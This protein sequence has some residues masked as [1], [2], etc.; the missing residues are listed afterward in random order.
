MRLFPEI[1]FFAKIIMVKK[2][3]TRTKRRVVKKGKA[4]TKKLSA[5]FRAVKSAHK[6][7]MAS[8][9]FKGKKYVRAY[10]R[11]VN[12]TRLVAYKAAK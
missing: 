11:G 1:F 3:P 2:A 9:M 10:Y 12:G 5:Y 8:F 7:K 6:Q 4:P